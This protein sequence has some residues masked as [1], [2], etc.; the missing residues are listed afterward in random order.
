M[1]L[2]SCPVS[3]ITVLI[4]LFR[5]LLSAPSPFI[6]SVTPGLTSLYTPSKETNERVSTRPLLR[7]GHEVSIV[8]SNKLPDPQQY[9]LD[10]R[11]VREDGTILL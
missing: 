1:P 5:H 2:S 10:A 7:G 3:G 8:T 9:L 6:L 4:C 11:L